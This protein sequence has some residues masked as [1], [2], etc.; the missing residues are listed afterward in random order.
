MW[1]PDALVDRIGGWIAAGDFEAG[2]I[3]LRPSVEGACQQ[4]RQI[5]LSAVEA[6]GPLFGHRFAPDDGLS[7]KKS[8]DLT[9]RSS[10]CFENG[11]GVR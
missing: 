8:V 7:F 4:E 11:S 2:Q 3:G 9:V 1:Q 10:R 6:V 5:Q